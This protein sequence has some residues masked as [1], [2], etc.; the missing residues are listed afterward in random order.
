MNLYQDA[1]CDQWPVVYSWIEDACENG[2]GWWTVNKLIPLL[3]EGRAVLWV[4]EDKHEPVAA[5]ITAIAD[6][7]GQRVAEIIATGG[8]GVI[9]ALNDELSKVEDWAREQGASEIMFR[10]RRGWARVYKPHGYEEIAVT[11]RK[12]L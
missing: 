3:C 12:A 6:W 7:D 11:M 4:L 2:D 1:N 9:G 5:V 8:A 10:G